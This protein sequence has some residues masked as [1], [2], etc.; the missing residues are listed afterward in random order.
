MLS[1]KEQIQVVMDTKSKIVFDI[2]PKRE[3]LSSAAKDNGKALVFDV[4]PKFNQ[5]T[6]YVYETALIGSNTELRV[7]LAKNLTTNK[8]EGDIKPIDPV[9][10]PKIEPII[11][12]II[13]K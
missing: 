12:P 8:D 2:M 4:V 7:V 5:L 13:N 1:V 10:D 6:E 3:D 9:I 11:E